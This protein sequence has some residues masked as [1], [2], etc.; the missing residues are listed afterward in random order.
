M[1]NGC[2]CVQWIDHEENRGA[3]ATRGNQVHR[4]EWFT[5]LDF[6]DD[7]VVLAEMLETL[8]LCVEDSGTRD[9]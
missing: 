6:A 9:A 3:E 4:S 5:D 7:V 8:V 2:F 1:Q